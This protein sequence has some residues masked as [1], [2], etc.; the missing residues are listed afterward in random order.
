MY[1]SSNYRIEFIILLNLFEFHIN[2]GKFRT[3]EFDSNK[4][5]EKCD[6]VLCPWAYSS[7]SLK[8]GPPNG[9]AKTSFEAHLPWAGSSPVK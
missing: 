3:I 6:E 4:S 2:F 1:F 5:L 9:L 8:S 7:W